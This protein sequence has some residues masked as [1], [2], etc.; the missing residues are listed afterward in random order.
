LDPWA[1]AAPS[2]GFTNDDR[3]HR[4]IDTF[5]IS[6]S[7]NISPNQA[8]TGI[9]DTAATRDQHIYT[10]SPNLS[11]SNHGFQQQAVSTPNNGSNNEW[12]LD[13][14][15]APPAWDPASQ[16][17]AQYSSH[18]TSGF[19]QPFMPTLDLAD[20]LSVYSNAV[21]NGQPDQTLQLSDFGAYNDF[22]A[23]PNSFAYPTSFTQWDDST[24]I[25]PQETMVSFNQLPLPTTTDIP[26]ALALP[27]NVTNMFS[28]P[29]VPLPIAR[30]VVPR[31][32]NGNTNAHTCDFTGCGKIFSSPGC[33]ARHRMQHGVPQHPCLIGGCNRRRSKAFYRAD[34]LRDHQRKKHRM[35]I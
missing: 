4:N 5:V 11:P 24:A 12:N 21:T 9:L 2:S 33:L 31:R 16:R 29:M 19:G 22:V 14:S 18:M 17:F 30:R 6:P 20:N 23:M 3:I 34:K 27:T 32:S 1:L 13:I 35:A 15:F 28:T 10:W 26:A 25:D 8:L 7:Y